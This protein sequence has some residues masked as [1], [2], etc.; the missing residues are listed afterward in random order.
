[1]ETLTQRHREI[2][3]KIVFPGNRILNLNRTYLMG[4]LNVTPDSF[5]DG[6]Q[7][8][9][10]E[11]AVS[12]ALE[13]LQQGADII[14]IGGES[15]RPGAEPVPLEVELERTVPVIQ[16]IIRESP[17]AL[18]SIDTYKAK[19]AEAALEAGAGLVNDISGLGFDADLPGVIARTGV[20]VVIMHIKGT[21]RNM[22]ANPYYDDLISEIIQ[23]FHERINLAD[24]AGIS[25]KQI[26]I[27]PGLGFAK[28]LTHN[29]EILNRLKEI[30][31]LGYPVMLGP[32][33]KSFIGKLL[34]RPTG[35][36]LLGTAAVVAAAVLQ[37]VPFV[38]VHDVRE[39]KQVI[40]VCEAIKNPPSS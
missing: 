4:I 25:A 37:D 19:V 27:D 16:S 5:S 1:M 36:R 12:R 8:N 11:K 33:R 30:Q 35:E 22:Q 24:S 2:N 13:M 38:R 14:D 9:I 6:G 20:P 39:I 21:P 7:F 40:T 29:Y 17:S 32:S 10:R 23:Y 15:T 18:I 28:T 31:S 26:I 3:R 34:D